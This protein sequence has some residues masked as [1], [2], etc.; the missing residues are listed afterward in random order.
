LN[1]EQLEF[2]KSERQWFQPHRIAHASY[3]LRKAQ[4]KAEMAFWRAVI[5]L[6]TI[7]EE[8]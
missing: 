8:G 1:L 5:K 6:N 4:S 3:Q 7:D 2:L